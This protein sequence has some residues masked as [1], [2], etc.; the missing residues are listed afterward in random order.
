MQSGI[1]TTINSNLRARVDGSFSFRCALESEHAKLMERRGMDEGLEPMPLIDALVQVV[2]DSLTVFT[3]SC[4]SHRHAD[5]RRQVFHCLEQ[6]GSEASDSTTTPPVSV[7][8]V[9]EALGER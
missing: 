1:K 8:A 7:A 3:A 9:R 4:S 6:A 5:V 2:I